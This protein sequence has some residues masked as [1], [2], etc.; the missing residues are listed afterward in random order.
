MHHAIKKGL[1]FG[2]SS[3]IITVMGIIVGTHSATDLK[4]AIIAA[5]I[6]VASADSLSDLFGVHFSEKA[7]KDTTNSEAWLSAFVTFLTKLIFGLTFL[8][9]IFAFVNLHTAIIADLIYGMSV[10]A[11][12]VYFVA[13]SRNEGI[14]FTIIGQVILALV[15]IAISHSV[16]LWVDAKFNI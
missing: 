11:I 13:K 4:H 5:I 12:Y 14:V 6:I 8:I 3:A 7:A 15:V 9:P 16:G 2:L 10:L 1:S